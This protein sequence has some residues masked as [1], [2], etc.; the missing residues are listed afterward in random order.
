MKW[1]IGNRLSIELHIEQICLYVWNQ[2]EFVRTFQ[3]DHFFIEHMKEILHFMCKT[4]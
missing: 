4:N 3:C 1:I 2:M